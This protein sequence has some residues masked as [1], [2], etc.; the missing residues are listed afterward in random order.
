MQYDSSQLRYKMLLSWRLHLRNILKRQ[1]D[2]RI[3][4]RFFATRRAWVTWLGVMKAR[5]REK[6]VSELKTR[7]LAKVF[8]GEDIHNGA[9]L[10]VTDYQ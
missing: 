9:V 1:K 3:A 7:K 6:Q 8:R 2:A 4:N 10:S 5:K